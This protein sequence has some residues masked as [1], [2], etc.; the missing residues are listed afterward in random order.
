MLHVTFSN[1]ELERIGPDADAL[2]ARQ[3]MSDFLRWIA[4][5]PPGFHA[6]TRRKR[7]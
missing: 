1:V 7:S 5:K 4:D 3:D 2:R 6:P